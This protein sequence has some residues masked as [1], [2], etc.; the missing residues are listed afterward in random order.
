MNK[1]ALF[2]V[3]KLNGLGFYLAVKA[4]YYAVEKHSGQKRDDGK[5]DYVDHSVRVCRM[6]LNLG[7]RDEVI[8]TAA[9]LHDLVEEGKATLEEIRKEF[10]DEV[11]YLVNA[12][13]QRK[14]ESDEEHIERLS[15]EIKAIVIKAAD[16]VCNVDDMTEVFS[17]ERLEKYTEE[18]RRIILPLMKMARRRYIEHSDLLIICRDYIKGIL[19]GAEKIIAL[20]KENASLKGELEKT[21]IE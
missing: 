11:C 9:P 2:I 19:N 3:G 18:T 17:L 4:I 14:D 10:G 16:R 5:T 20:K 1:E 7:I 21:N 15:K 6:L 8:L 12:L 13:S